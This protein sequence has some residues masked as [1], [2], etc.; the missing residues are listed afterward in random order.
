MGVGVAESLTS[1]LLVPSWP[2]ISRGPCDEVVGMNEQRG[3]GIDRALGE[4]WASASKGRGK[5]RVHL[6][7]QEQV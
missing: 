7:S 4:V 1:K 2:L 6:D 3:N 5:V